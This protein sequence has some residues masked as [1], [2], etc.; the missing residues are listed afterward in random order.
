MKTLRFSLAAILIACI[1]FL[2]QAQDKKVE[3]GF[4][5]GYGHTM[6]RL[7]DSRTIKYPLINSANLNGFHVGPIFKFNIEEQLAIQTGVFFNYFSGVNLISSAA[8][9][10]LGTWE[11]D[12]TNLMAFD[13]PIRFMYSVPLAEE[14]YF[15]VFAGPNLNYSLNKVTINEI[16]ADH[17]LRTSTTGENIYKKPSEFKPLDLQIGAGLGVQ[18]MG[19]SL[20]GSYDWGVLNRTIVENATLRSNDIKVSLGYS[21]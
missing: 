15:F 11:Q 6:P 12:K 18:W 7:K 5:A 21:F 17:K 20:R 19:V 1:S 13:L 4:L 2:G 10:K 14:F 9:K 3:V 8:M 16:Y